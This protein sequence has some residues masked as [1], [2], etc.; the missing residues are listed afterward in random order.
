VQ[1][2]TKVLGDE[3]GTVAITFDLDPGVAADAVA[4]AGDFN[5]W[6]IDANPM[7]RR[8]DGSFHTTVV[9]ELGREYR[10]RYVLDG[11]RW[12]NAWDAD[13]YA[14]NDFGGEDSVVRTDDVGE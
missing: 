7:A 3:A 11:E 12:V 2:I 14:P 9:L 6:S 8:P 4:V 10:F 5:G 13:D 1:V